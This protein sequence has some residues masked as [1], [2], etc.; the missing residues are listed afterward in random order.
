[1]ASH[2]EGATTHAP[3]ATHVPPS[4]PGVTRFYARNTI[5]EYAR[6][7]VAG[8]GLLLQK[9]IPLTCVWK[10]FVR[11][12]A[13]GAGGRRR[14]LSASGN[15]CALRREQV[16]GSFVVPCHREQ[17]AHRVPVARSPEGAPRRREAGDE[18]MRCRASEDN[19]VR[20]T[21][22][23]REPCA[24]THSAGQIARGAPAAQDTLGVQGRRS[25]PGTRGCKGPSFN[26]PLPAGGITR[27]GV[28]NRARLSS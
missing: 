13:S 8:T 12:Y 9:C 21:S 3:A 25:P 17:C 19:V 5:N 6:H 23:H 11:R 26:G 27:S 1:M 15:G 20:V 22:W 18:G 7:H 14:R 24:H 4:K 28:V 2:N 10:T 16:K